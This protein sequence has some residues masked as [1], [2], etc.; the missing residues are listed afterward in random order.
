MIEESRYPDS[1]FTGSDRTLSELRSYIER[2]L[3]ASRPFDP[4]P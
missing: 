4:A 1:L 3:N 2:A